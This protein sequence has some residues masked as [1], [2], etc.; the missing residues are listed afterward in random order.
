MK[1]VIYAVVIAAC[2]L[3]AVVVFM[4]TRGGGSTGIDSISDSEMI[5]MKCRSC[6]HAYEM[7]YKEYN[8]QIQ[9]KMT[10]S[11]TAMMVTPL[12]TCEKCGKDRASKAVKCANAKC[13]EVFIEGSV[14]NDFPDRC[15]KCK[16]SAVEDSRNARL[17]GQQ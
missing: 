17:Q 13:G 11:P 4:K 2:I 10:A 5:W 7:S 3:V 16:H 8:K 6:N 15:P 1:N 9:E 14:P 12:L